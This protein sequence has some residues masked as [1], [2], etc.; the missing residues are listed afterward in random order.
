MALSYYCKSLCAQSLTGGNGMNVAIYNYETTV[1]AMMSGSC[2]RV[3]AG[4]RTA[5]E[6]SVVSRGVLAAAQKRAA[7]MWGRTTLNYNSGFPVTRPAH[8][9]V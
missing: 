8:C 9:S 3:F 2:T 5:V 4:T 1:S 7:L 6:A